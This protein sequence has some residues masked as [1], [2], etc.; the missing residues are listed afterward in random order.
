MVCWHFVPPAKRGGSNERSAHAALQWRCL[1]SVIARDEIPK[2]AQRKLNSSGCF[3]KRDYQSERNKGGFVKGSV[4]L[5]ICKRC[6]FKLGQEIKQG[7]DNRKDIK[8]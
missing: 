5:R 7:T 8:I 2:Q 1:A 4:V 6:G 3:K